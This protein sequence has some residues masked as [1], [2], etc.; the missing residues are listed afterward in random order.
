MLW[1]HLVDDTD[2]VAHSKLLVIVLGNGPHVRVSWRSQVEDYVKADAEMV[3]QAKK[4]K[5]AMA[6]LSKWL[7]GGANQTIDTLKLQITFVSSIKLQ[8]PAVQIA[9]RRA[10]RSRIVSGQQRGS[11]G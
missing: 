4:T 8:K 9:G 3:I 1:Q 2:K 6:C 11:S 7:H 5:M 10:E